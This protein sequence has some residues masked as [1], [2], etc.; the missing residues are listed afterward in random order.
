M[1]GWLENVKAKWYIYKFLHENLP[2][3][4][5][6]THIPITPLVFPLWGIGDRDGG[7]TK[8]KE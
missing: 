5:P 6:N 3:E 7:I 4:E 8:I 2:Q 1:A